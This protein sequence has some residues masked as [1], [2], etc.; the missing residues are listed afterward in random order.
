MPRHNPPSAEPTLAASNLWFHF[1]KD[2]RDG[3]NHTYRGYGLN[4][5]FSNHR[6][7]VFWR[8]A[9]GVNFVAGRIEALANLLRRVL[10]RLLSV[11]IFG[12]PLVQER[13]GVGRYSDADYESDLLDRF[14]N[15]FDG[16]RIYFSHN[17]LK[18]FHYLEQI[19]PQLK[20]RNS[21]PYILEIGAGLFNFGHLLSFRFK[22]FAYVVVDLPEVQWAARSEISS[23]PGR[24]YDLFDSS[25]LNGFLQSAAPRRVLFL[26][27]A[28]LGKL[29]GKITFDLFVNHESFAEMPLNVVNS[30]LHQVKLLLDPGALLFLVNRISR[31]Q[32]LNKSE[33]ISPEMVTDF[34]E[35]DL[36]GVQVLSKELDRF[37][38]RE[39]FSRI[40]SQNYSLIGKWLQKPDH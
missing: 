18:A 32:A 19:T 26:E 29:Q 5:T 6:V 30:Y 25:T 10:L 14:E 38:M 33:A 37:R 34:A 36:G 1:L 24:N 23:Y 27:P 17:T 39:G 28:E 4:H 31:I 9:R 3:S 21:A 12:G 35:Y 22:H 8:L 20:L 7:R 15:E 16:K 11:L 13:F 2:F 40:D